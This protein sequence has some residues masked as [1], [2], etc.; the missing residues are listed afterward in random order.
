MSEPNDEY[1]PKILA[2][3]FGL[4]ENPEAESVSIRLVVDWL[5]DYFPCEVE[6]DIREGGDVAVAALTKDGRNTAKIQKQEA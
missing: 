6:V 3:L 5:D 2:K 4:D 1:D